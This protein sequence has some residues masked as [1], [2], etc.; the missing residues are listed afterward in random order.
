MLAKSRLDRPRGT[1]NSMN[2]MV[3][4]VPTGF[5]TS[6]T[7]LPVFS[8]TFPLLFSP[9]R[10]RGAQQCLAERLVVLLGVAEEGELDLPAVTCLCSNKAVKSNEELKGL[11]SRKVWQVVEG[12]V[13][14][15]PYSGLTLGLLLLC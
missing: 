8:L 5:V 14:A 10:L 7:V 6:P 2:E 12:Q 13:Q 15:N 1:L 9:S 3:D 11:I 4:C